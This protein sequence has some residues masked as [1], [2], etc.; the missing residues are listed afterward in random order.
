MNN[1]ASLS[2]LVDNLLKE[3]REKTDFGYSDYYCGQNFEDNYAAV[4]NEHWMLE[5]TYMATEEGGRFYAIINSL[6]V[7]EYDENEEDFVK[8][9]IETYNEVYKDL[10]RELEDLN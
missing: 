10:E 1:K 9:D 2:N 6:D 3:I 8:V 7:C 5:I 4:E